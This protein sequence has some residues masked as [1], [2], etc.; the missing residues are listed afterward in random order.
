MVNAVINLHEL[1]QIGVRL[2]SIVHAID[3]STAIGRGVT[4][5]LTALAEAEVEEQQERVRAGIRR[6]RE[7]GTS[8]PAGVGTSSKLSWRFS[9]GTWKPRSGQLVK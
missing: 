3:T 1:T 8:G 6:V 7:D 2:V 5:L 4:A 9:A